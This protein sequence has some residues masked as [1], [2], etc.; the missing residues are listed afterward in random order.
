MDRYPINAKILCIPVKIHK[1][2][3]DPPSVP[4]IQTH[5]RFCLK[6]IKI[7]SIQV[8]HVTG[9]FVDRSG[10]A[11]NSLKKRRHQ[12]KESSA[13]FDQILFHP[14]VKPVDRNSEEFTF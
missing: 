9:S 7:I 10:D 1:K 13:V 2:K 3:T 11:Q 8:I 14:A 12:F 5:S 6:M 4:I